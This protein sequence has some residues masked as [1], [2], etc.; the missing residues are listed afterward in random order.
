MVIFH[1]YVKLPEGISLRSGITTGRT[2]PQ[3]I[4]RIQP[5]AH[6]ATARDGGVTVL[7]AGKVN[8][9]GKKNL[10]GFRLGKTCG[11][12]TETWIKCWRKE[13]KLTETWSKIWKNLGK[14]MFFSQKKLLD[15][16]E[17]LG[18]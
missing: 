16:L 10:G 11:F 14:S 18:F 1:S 17:N 4:P 12:S 9:L 2:I 3:T 7:T 13:E 15:A 8:F 6:R 5:S